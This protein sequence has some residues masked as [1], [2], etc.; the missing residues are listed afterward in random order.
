MSSDIIGRL[1]TIEG[2]EGV[3]KSTQIALL[4]AYCEDRGIDAVFTREPGGTAI[5][6]RIRDIIL[7]KDS[8]INL[9]TELLLYNAARV[10]HIDKVIIP[11]LLKGKTVFCDRF[12]D[13]TMAYQGYGRGI[14]LEIIDTFN[15]VVL[16]GLRI[17]K[18]IFLD[19]SPREGFLRKGGADKEDRMD[20]ETMEFHERVYEGFLEIASLCGDRVTRIDASG[21]V[22]EV[23]EMVLREVEGAIEN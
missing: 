3:G 4:K 22:G 12:I 9:M 1:I 20:S 6:E 13:S 8:N 14:D 18:T 2:C 15:D 7:H 16:N 11:A 17:D 23:F 19:M 21:G 10:E 5:A